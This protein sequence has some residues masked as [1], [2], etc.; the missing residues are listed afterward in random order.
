MGTK[1]TLESVQEHS[2]KHPNEKQKSKHT[3][4]NKESKRERKKK[5]YMVFLS[6][7]RM[8]RSL[9]LICLFCRRIFSESNSPSP[10]DS[11]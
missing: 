1:P 11:S 2:K 4:T 10:V 7:P 3:Q 6:L 5:N 9:F 8:D